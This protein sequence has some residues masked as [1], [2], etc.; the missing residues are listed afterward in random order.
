[1]SESI[2]QTVTRLTS[3]IQGI[4]PQADV[5]P[6]SALSE[7][8]IKLSSELDNQ[9]Y[10]QINTYGQS[11]SVQTALASTTPTI[12]PAID[13]VASNFLATR[14]AGSF[15]TGNLK[16]ILSTNQN[17][18]I[19]QGAI[20]IQSS[21]N[22]N[23]VT[24]QSYTYSINASTTNG[25][26]P[27]YSQ[28]GLYYLIVPVQ[29]S[30]V[31]SQYQVSDQTQFTLGSNYSNT[32]IVSIAAY[33]NFSS[34]LPEETDQALISKFQASAAQ[35]NLTSP[36]GINTYLTNNFPG[37]QN[38]TV[39][40]AG[41][42]LMIR[43]KENLFGIATNGQADI[44][45]RTSVGPS[46]ITVTLQGIKLST[47][48][49]Q[50]TIPNTACPGFY[51]IK[52]I[53]P[54]P[55]NNLVNSAGTLVINSVI[56][57]YSPINTTRNNFIGSIT[58][59]R[60]SSY[61]N[62]VVNL[63]YTESPNL[64]N[65]STL[66]FDITFYYQPNILPIQQVF[67]A[68]ATRPPNSDNLVKACVPC[69]C[70]L[71]MTLAKINSTDTFTSLNL[72]NL[73]QAIFNYINTIPIGGNVAAS[74]IISLSMGYNIQRVELPILLTGTIYTPTGIN[75]VITSNDELVIPTDLTNL[76]S[77]TNVQYFIDYFTASTGNVTPSNNIVINL[78]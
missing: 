57:G 9:I 35:G 15:S 32:S 66:N 4:N 78:V 36:A 49:W 48:I 29:A 74:Q 67:L 52:G 8:V 7:L 60:F 26:S 23:Y 40:G 45:T 73:Q 21:L 5:S 43:C 10:N 41:D 6:G 59:A 63:Q 50:I 55:V 14:F 30:A 12:T 39:V 1:M 58:D 31:G 62:A 56:Y 47:G 19:P 37:F 22:L 13:N 44:Y 70:T 27:I 18:I 69:F 61:Q 65:G 77:P 54:T 2:S 71:Q 33:G 17:I 53:L 3:F 76:I 34:G 20:F 42:P 75:E 25:Y 38:C 11:S 68:D 64:A 16:V 28:N 46:T 72:A 24:L 51:F